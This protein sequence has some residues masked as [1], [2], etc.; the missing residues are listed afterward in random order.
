MTADWIKEIPNWEKEYSSM[1]DVEI[2][3][4]QREL[5]GGAEIKSNEG[6][7][8]GAMYSDWKKRK[9]KHIK[10]TLND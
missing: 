3:K 10:E 2:T 4:R 1:E 5:L 9:E 6:M 7:V 8:Y